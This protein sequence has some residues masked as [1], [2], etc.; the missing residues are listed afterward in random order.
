MFSSCN[1]L[2]IYSCWSHLEHTVSVKCFVSLQFLYLRQLVGLLGW[3]S[4]RCKAATYTGQHKHRIS[5][6]IHASS[7]I[8]TH[9]PSVRGGKDISCLRMHSHCEQPCN[10]RWVKISIRSLPLSWRFSAFSVGVLADAIFWL[11]ELYC[12]RYLEFALRWKNS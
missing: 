8:R 10:I 9:N 3:G 6:N 5:A 11:T 4:A 12:S 1:I 7:G 2:S